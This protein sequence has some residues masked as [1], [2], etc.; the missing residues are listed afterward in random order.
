[1]APMKLT[2][3]AAL[4][5]LALATTTAFGC[6]ADDGGRNDGPGGASG[7]ADDL[8]DDTDGGPSGLAHRD[9]VVTCDELAE[10]ITDR[11]NDARVDE[12]VAAQRN[13]QNC[14]GLA[15]DSVVDVIDNGLTNIESADA[16]RTESRFVTYR[17]AMQDLCNA[18]VEASPGA[19]DKTGA[20]LSQR[21]TAD[22]ERNLADII[23]AYVALSTDAITIPESRNLYGG[24]YDAFDD[25]GAVGHAAEVDA[26]ESLAACLQQDNDAM[27]M[28]VMDKI[29]ANFPGRSPSDLDDET[30][31]YLRGAQDAI[32]NLCSTVAFVGDATD[33]AFVESQYSLCIVAGNAQIGEL[34]ASVDAELIGDGGS[35]GGDTGGSDSGGSDG[36]SDSGGATGTGG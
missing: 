20:L 1:M 29:V 34:A 23:D 28:T 10:R 19:L 13:R 9:W 3:A 16:G 31:R 11:T 26:L 30:Y 12:E 17:D 35:A 33:D 25:E 7:K 32:D 14:L 36:G 15:N 5:S 22:G 24:C 21:C 27:R 2:H 18:F 8:D 4:L 6:G